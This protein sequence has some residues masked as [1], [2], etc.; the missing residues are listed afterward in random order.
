MKG[1]SIKEMLKNAK[2]EGRQEVISGLL[3]YI[4]QEAKSAN[5]SFNFEKSR[6]EKSSFNIVYGKEILDNI[7]W[8]D[9]ARKALGVVWRK[10]HQIR[11]KSNKY[12]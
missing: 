7:N 6:L 12:A 1:L 4:K 3:A 11:K 2:E 8:W 5:N 9:G 10:I